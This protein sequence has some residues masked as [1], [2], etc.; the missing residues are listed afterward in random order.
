MTVINH[1]LITLND[2]LNALERLRDFVADLD[3]ED[4]PSGDVLATLRAL[5]D[6]CEKEG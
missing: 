3:D 2:H 5:L 6:A 4:L 1:N